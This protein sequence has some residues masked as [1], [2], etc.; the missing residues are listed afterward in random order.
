M[1]IIEIQQLETSEEFSLTPYARRLSEFP[2]RIEKLYHT[3][4]VIYKRLERMKSHQVCN[5][6]SDKGGASNTLLKSS[7]LNIQKILAG[8]K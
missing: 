8:A 6:S 1:F 3:L 5:G 7:V 2:A 4:D